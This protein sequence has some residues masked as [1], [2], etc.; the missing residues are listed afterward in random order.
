[1]ETAVNSLL[2]EWGGISHDGASVANEDE[3]RCR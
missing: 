1:M 2:V 3:E